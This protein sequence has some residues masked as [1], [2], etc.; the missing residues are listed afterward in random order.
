M[1]NLIITGGTRGIGLATVKTFAAKGFNVAFCARDKT[2]IEKLLDELKVAYPQQTFLGVPTDL[3]IKQEVEEFADTVLKQFASINL[4]VNNAGIFEPGG[5][6]TEAEGVFERQMAT[7]VSSAYYL[8]RALLPH[9]KNSSGHIINICSTASFIPYVN[10]GSYCISKFALLGLGK[11]L[12][13]ELKPRGIRV[14]SIMPGA[15]LTDSWA[16]TDLPPSRFMQANDVA[17][18]IWDLNHLPPT[19]V[20][21]ELIM[22]PMKGDI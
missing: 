20:I 19:S 7:N 8:T 12:R 21:E 10:G 16:G 22:R 9:I 14:T 2:T 1:K 17:Q 15:T 5:I 4:L 6:S 18:A 13:E 11:V 3:T